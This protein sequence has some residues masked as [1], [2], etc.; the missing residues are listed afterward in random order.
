MFDRSQIFC[1]VKVKN[2]LFSKWK[3]KINTEKLVRNNNFCFRFILPDEN[4]I[5]IIQ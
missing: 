2:I 5:Y 3:K 4:D 1:I